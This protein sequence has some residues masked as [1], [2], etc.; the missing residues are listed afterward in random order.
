MN[1]KLRAIRQLTPLLFLLLALP[2]QAQES[3]PT[4][5]TLTPDLVRQI[6]AGVDSDS[7]RLQAIFKDIH[8][9]PELGFM[10]TRTAAIVARELEAQGYEVKTKIGKT[11]VVGILKNGEG[12]TVMFRADMDA[13]A[14]AETTGLPYA[15]EARVKM[16]DGSETAVAHLCGHDAHTTWLISLARTMAT[17]R[18]QWR[19]TLIL[20]AQPAEE[21][22][23]G[24][25]A[26]AE[27]GLFT[28]HAVPEP[29]YLLALHTAPVPTGVVVGSG[30]MLMA[31]SEQLDVIFH[32]IG[33]HGSSPHLT[34]DPI[35][36]GAYAVSE[37]QSI[38]SRLLD[39]RDMGVITVGAFHAGENN[40]VIPETATLKL[41]F[42]FFSS[43]TH[44]QLFNGVQSVSNGI[45]R[46]YGMPEE[47]L[48]TIIRKGYNTPLVNDA[49][50]MERLNRALLDS[51][52]VGEETLVTS[53][54]PVTGSEDVQMLVQDLDG[55]KIVY[56]FIGTAEPSLVAAARARGQEFPFSN[57]SPNYQVDLNAIAFGAKV[58]AIMTM[59]LMVA[60]S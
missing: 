14:A 5:S 8:Q 25:K 41:N 59:E 10:E 34:R 22:V 28:E 1:A 2:I 33:G 36:M 11:G 39:P 6:I 32:G 44:E 58:A 40:N 19:G 31:G 42:R 29:Q 54:R 30:G 13:N 45:A 23:A 53:F 60:D 35:L 9:N 7:D 20:L 55:V 21:L 57:H 26:M 50:L 38:V 49:P 15:S 37:Y 12:P 4:Q 48:P 17:L 47:K 51:G 56:D 46:T 3:K 52:V 16:P 27:D 43:K 24:A 18:D